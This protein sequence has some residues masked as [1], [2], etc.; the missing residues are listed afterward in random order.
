[1]VA[2]FREGYLERVIAWIDDL[3]P[4]AYEPCIKFLDKGCH[5]VVEDLLSQ[6]KTTLARVRC[7]FSSWRVEKC[8]HSE[9]FIIS[10]PLRTLEITVAHFSALF[11]LRLTS[12][13][14]VQRQPRPL[15]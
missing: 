6:A 12:R 7:P 11:F 10:S 2:L 13:V 1:M 3:I 4:D 14:R 5:V 15:C 9:S 8:F